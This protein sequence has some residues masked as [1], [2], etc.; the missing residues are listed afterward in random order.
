MDNS[1]NS[2]PEQADLSELRKQ[3]KLLLKKL[4]G[5]DEGAVSTANTHYRD[6]D[7]A[8]FQLSDAQLVVARSYGFSS[9]PKLA[10][11][12]Q[13][14]WPKKPAEPL[15]YQDVFLAVKQ[16]E[17]EKV[18]SIV[19]AD[20][21]LLDVADSNQITPLTIA[22]AYG[23]LDLAHALI[24]RGAN[25]FAM[26]HSDKWGMRYITEKGGLTDED[27]ERFVETAIASRVWEEKIFHAV[28]R[29]DVGQAKAALAEKPTTVSLRL[30]DA[31][32]KSGFYNGLPYCG[33][34][35]CTTRSLPAM[36]RW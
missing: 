35:R 31:D 14:Q 30:A 26:N 9:W 10:S 12:I 1:P 34:T 18:L 7:V 21:T 5:D 11:Y 3:A 20:E 25:V 16:G 4:R 29:G 8:K 23:H 2:L 6:L 15:H 24:E 13:T 17:T 28:W 36:S 19:D 32:G 33:L 27:R 22:F